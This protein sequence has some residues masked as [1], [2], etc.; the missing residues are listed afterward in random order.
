VWVEQVEKALTRASKKEQKELDE[1]SKKAVKD[2]A[3][4]QSS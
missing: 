1:Q 4:T 2:A 3:S